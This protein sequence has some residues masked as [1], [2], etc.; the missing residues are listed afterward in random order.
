MRTWMGIYEKEGAVDSRIIMAETFEEAVSAML[1]DA[2]LCNA[3]IKV[4]FE[5]AR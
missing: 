1:W 5:V 2:E 4:I 3:D